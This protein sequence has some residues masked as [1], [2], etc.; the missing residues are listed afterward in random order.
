[1]I[2]TSDENSRLP[3]AL[4][5]SLMLLTS[6]LPPYYR[7]EVLPQVKTWFVYVRS[8]AVLLSGFYFRMLNCFILSFVPGTRFFL[9]GPQ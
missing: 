4:L 3:V 9:S 7:V 2:L 6:L 8:V 1:M 5:D